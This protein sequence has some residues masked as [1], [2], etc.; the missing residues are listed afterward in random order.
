MTRT[1]FNIQDK[2]LNEKIQKLEN[3][4][5]SIVDVIELLKQ[6]KDSITP[7]LQDLYNERQSLH[8][9]YYN[10]KGRSK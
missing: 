1:D 3:D 4:I 6:T 9:E 7:V 2:C 8:D 10:Q 5:S